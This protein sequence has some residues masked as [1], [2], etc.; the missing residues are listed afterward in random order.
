MRKKEDPEISKIRI[1]ARHSLDKDPGAKNVDIFIGRKLKLRRTLLKMSQDSLGS[2]VGLTFQQVQKYESGE[3][4]ISASRLFT[5]SR[6]LRVDIG[7]FFDGLDSEKTM[8]F[9][10]PERAAGIVTDVA[11]QFDSVNSAESVRL[12][13]LFWKIPDAN[14]RRK[15]LDILET[16]G[17]Y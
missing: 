4:K 3:N 5:F 9:D 1:A 16:L 13:S 17:G 2:I 10:L 6:I 11:R 12:L 7:Y 14:K 15:Y 8:Q